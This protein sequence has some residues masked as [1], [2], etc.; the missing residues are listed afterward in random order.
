MIE[1]NGC[2]G[3]KIGKHLIFYNVGLHMRDKPHL[4]KIKRISN[5]PGN[6][7]IQPSRPHIVTL[8]IRDRTVY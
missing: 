2:V 8:N 3:F 4:E 5:L 7:E 1:A 6:G